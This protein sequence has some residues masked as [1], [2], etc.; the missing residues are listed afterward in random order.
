[1]KVGT[2][3][4]LLGSWAGNGL[5]K[6]I[7]DVGTGTGVIAMMLA[8]RN[9]QAVIHAIDIDGAAAKQ[10]TENV[11][12][13]P[14]ADRMQVFHSSFAE[15]I[16][17]AS[18]EY[19]LIVSNPPYY[20]RSMTSR[21][22][23]RNMARHDGLLPDELLRGAISLLTGDGALAVIL[24]A[25]TEES[26]RAEGVSCGLKITR[27]TAVSTLENRP[28]KRILA[29][30]TADFSLPCISETMFIETAAKQYSAAF[31]SLTAPFYEL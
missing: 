17:S 20:S 30:M 16:A 27:L 18:G 11:K 23:G 2:D 22:A 31:R 8:Q 15:Y 13:S 1:M 4:V 9:P 25:E 12:A 14:F 24:P 10:A 26:L 3:G 7:L 29:E 21:D 19:D 28:P 6:R 5:H